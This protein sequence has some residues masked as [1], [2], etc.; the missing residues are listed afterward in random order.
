[1]V[2]V[3][4]Q[5]KKKKVRPTRQAQCQ[6]CGNTFTQYTDRAQ[7]VN[8]CAPCIAGDKGLQ[9]FYGARLKTSDYEVD[10]RRKKHD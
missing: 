8:H 3:V 5:W 4:K 10:I 6:E 1:M 7:F 2:K 9:E